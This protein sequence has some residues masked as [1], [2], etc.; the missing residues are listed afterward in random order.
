MFPAHPD[1]ALMAN[2]A[3]PGLARAER[4][5]TLLSLWLARFGGVLLV[6]CAVLIAAEVVLR[7]ITSAI[8][9]HSFELSIYGFATA[10]AFGFGHVLLARAHIRIDILYGSCLLYT[11]PSPRDQRGSR[12]PS[13]A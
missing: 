13:S 1:I 4:T 10:L 7:N 2:T 6:V 5:V 12:M 3:I 9:L 8:K 11:S